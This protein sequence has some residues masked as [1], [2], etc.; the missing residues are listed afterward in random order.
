M[1]RSSHRCPLVCFRRE[2]NAHH[3]GA[4]AIENARRPQSPIPPRTAG[5]EHDFVFEIQKRLHF[6]VRVYSFFH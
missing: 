2:I 4:R 1:I 6:I 5:N 3:L